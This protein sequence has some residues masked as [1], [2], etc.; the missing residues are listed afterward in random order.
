MAPKSQGFVANIS[1]PGTRFAQAT[2]KSVNTNVDTSAGD[3]ISNLG[4]LF[5]GSVELAGGMAADQLGAETDAT[6]NSEITSSSTDP[7]YFEKK[8][9][10][11]KIVANITNPA[12]MQ[13]VLAKKKTEMIAA[14][15]GKKNQDLITKTFRDAGIVPQ[16]QF[17]SAVATADTDRRKLLATQTA[18]KLK[19]ARALGYV[20][21]DQEILHLLQTTQLNGGIVSTVST[22]GKAAGGSTIGAK[23]FRAKLIG[24]F[25]GGR[26]AI[27]KVAMGTFLP[28]LEEFDT[29]SPTRKAE[30]RVL[31]GNF[32]NSSKIQ[33]TR[34]FNQSGEGPGLSQA[35]LDYMVNPVV[36]LINMIGG[37]MGLN[38]NELT[39]EKGLETLSKN[40]KFIRDL[41]K[42]NLI[43]DAMTDTANRQLLLA[44]EFGGDVFAATLLNKIPELR[45]QIDAALEDTGA[46]S[47]TYGQGALDFLINGSKKFTTEAHK[48]F[49]Q[50][51]GK[52]LI[53]TV[54]PATIKDVKILENVMTMFTDGDL[55]LKSVK[56]QGV[57]LGVMNGGN[58]KGFIRALK[59]KSPDKAQQSIDFYNQNAHERY[60]QTIMELAQESKNNGVNIAIKNGRY[61]AI[62]EAQGLTELIDSANDALDS[63]LKFK[64]FTPDK[65]K[66]DIPLRTNII[67]KQW[68]TLL[69]QIEKEGDFINI[70]LSPQEFRDSKAFIKIG[71]PYF[72][73]TDAEKADQKQIDDK[74]LDR[75]I[76]VISRKPVSK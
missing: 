76:R 22:A 57:V 37:S 51:L 27:Q 66:S 44:K 38:S 11:L 62:G 8:R 52:E 3:F 33:L 21:T 53:K 46:D 14:N 73:L 10:E 68:P 69:S 42:N 13:L 20:G 59:S 65:N 49:N 56:N 61:E 31:M 5:A 7:A 74:K 12:L 34:Q 29:A 55:H 54:D 43:N 45:R 35:E 32:V 23:T 9:K 17:L 70:G 30:L 75:V 25:N 24:S 58:G 48:Q 71:T 16:G 64:E 72:M 18:T 50:T 36:G 41:V 19:D 39:E 26:D 2:P 47:K 63:V 6:I 1:E 67:N 4:N 15:P 28:M 40:S 60:T